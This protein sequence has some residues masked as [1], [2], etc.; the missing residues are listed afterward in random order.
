MINSF[1]FAATLKIIF[2]SGKLTML[3]KLTESY[4]NSVLVVTGKSSFIQSDHW[5]ELLQQFESAKLKW[6]HF[7]VAKEPTPELIDT[8]VSKFQDRAIDVVIAIGGGSVI[9]AGKAIS[10]MFKQEGSIRDYLEGVGRFEPSGDKVPFIAVPTTSGTGA[11]ATKNAVISEVGAQGFKKSLRHDRYVPN[12]ALLDPELTLNCPRVITAQSGMDAFTQLLE[13]YVSTNA[14]PMTDSLAV[15]GIRMIRDGLKQAV[16]DG[17]YLQAREKMAYASLISGITL[18]NA[19][20]GTIHGFASSIGGFFDIPHGLVCA[21]MMEPVNRLTISK[22]KSQDPDGIGLLKYARIGKLFSKDKNKPDGSYIELLL[23]VI[24]Q[25]TED[26]ELRKFAEF[27]VTPSDFSKIISATGNK[28]NP[29][30]LD[31][32]EMEEALKLTV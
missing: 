1:I 14:N 26:F 9:D 30:K 3:P 13:S 31:E 32:G 15:E 24:E 11:E 5:K 8:C 2:G 27:G 21:R 28:Y 12:I 22:L 19:G 10:A 23:D 7:I 16:M 6:E 4:G 20:L 18:A 17:T 25:W 29:V